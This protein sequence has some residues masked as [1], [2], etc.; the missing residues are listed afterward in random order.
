MIP[1]KSLSSIRSLLLSY[2]NTGVILCLVLTLAWLLR[3]GAASADPLPDIPQVR[4]PIIAVVPLTN[5]T[6]DEALAWIG[7]ALQETLSWEAQ[8]LTGSRVLDLRELVQQAKQLP[9]ALA[10]LRP[11]RLALLVGPL[12]VDVFIGGDYRGSSRQVSVNLFVFDRAKQAQVASRSFSEPMAQVVPGARQALLEMTQSPPLAVPSKGVQPSVQ[13]RILAPRA[14]EAHAHGISAMAES[15]LGG[16]GEAT[17]RAVGLFKQVVQDE[18][19]DGEAWYRLGEAL[20]RGAEYDEGRQ[21]L[22]HG[23]GLARATS[24]WVLELATL[25]SA[26]E[27]YLR[28]GRGVEAEPFFAQALP[29][30]RQS[31]DWGRQ[32]AALHGFASV[33]HLRGETERT[34][35][36]LERALECARATTNR[37]AEA[38]L[39]NHLGELRI[40]LGEHAVARQY[41]GE[42]VTLAQTIGDRRVERIGLNDLAVIAMRQG[43]YRE[44][45]GMLEKALQIARTLGDRRDEAL[46]LGNIGDVEALRGAYPAA[47]PILEEALSLARTVGASAIEVETLRTIG[48]ANF[49][50]GVYPEAQAAYEK[51]LRLA[52]TQRVPLFEGLMLHYLG[53]VSLAMKAFAEAKQYEEAALAI[54]Q[55][56]ASSRVEV[57][58]LH[59]LAEVQFARGDYGA[60]RDLFERVMDLAKRLGRSETLWGARYGLGRI[61]EV[62]GDKIAAL[63]QYREAV[64]VIGS[65]MRQFGESEE[66]QAFLANK[67]AV[68]DALT[69][70]LLQLHEQDSSK[71]YDQEAW[72]ILEAKK[73]RLAGEAL[74]AARPKL[75]DAQARGAVAQVQ[76]K[77]EQVLALEKALRTEQAKPPTTQR[78]ETIH[79]L[80]TQVAHTKTAYLA[81]VKAFL[82]HYPQYKAQFVDQHAVDP[83]TLAKFADELPPHTL[84]VQYFAAPDRLYCFVVAP[85]GRFQV[86]V[87]AVTQEELYGLIRQY[88][89]YIERGATRPLGWG[90]D[91]SEE[92]RRDVQP[93]KEVTRKLAAHL[94]APIEAEL[95]A[96]G[97]LIL[98]PNDQLLYLPIHALTRIQPDGSERFLA[99]THVVSYL[100]QQEFTSLFT[101]PAPS[102][103]APLLALANP[104]GS[105]PAASREVR[106]LRRIRPTITA[107]DGAEATKERFLDLAGQFPDLHLATHGILDKGRSELSYLLMAGADEESQ[108]LGIDEIAGLRLKRGM[109]VLSACDTAVGEQVPGAAL[110][111]LAAA[112][113]TAGAH[114]IVASLWQVNDASTRDFMV[115]FYKA[116]PTLGRAAALQQG[117]LTVLR[118]PATANPHYWAAFILIGAR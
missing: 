4:P 79:S 54:S 50:L 99:E 81:Q 51:G 32:I 98:L 82:A 95:Q 41:L 70:L 116:L 5:L 45:R 69:R 37:G 75:Q 7:V 58:A 89:K 74:A 61:F 18:P 101:A 44:A 22:S 105:L 106:E 118:N 53:Q 21:A 57:L 96:Y 78:P 83:R 94:L 11:D 90:E 29:L 8:R 6:G 14:L 49:A 38:R 12:G 25:I 66:R 48:W 73:G 110:I 93:L 55:Q 97:N 108:R 26:G 77:Q 107:L 28:Q 72:A 115:A 17:K 109:A 23:L 65:L 84:A 87:Q 76:A 46:I 63:A 62:Q 10:E 40:L 111:T 92:Y 91:G 3:D 16:G 102:A 88:R 103:T 43:A 113:S 13:W 34:K 85:G 86:K 100:T 15:L 31:G 24:D 67:L 35:E 36:Y 68:Y 60:S 33:F 27:S 39:L 112:F 20:V 30:A 56:I 19:A 71:G 47:F 59:G 9:V 52:R 1:R 104:D 2:R 114:A 42:A 80:T 117:Q 64:N